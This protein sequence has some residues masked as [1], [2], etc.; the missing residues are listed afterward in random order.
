MSHRVRSSLE[1]WK[2]LQA[3][4]ANPNVSY[5]P[6]FVDAEPTGGLPLPSIARLGGLNVPK[7]LAT[8]ADVW[9]ASGLPSK[10]LRRL[11]NFR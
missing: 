2:R 4:E 6:G 10:Q 9:F 1:E 8:G 5:V 7:K 11:C 3:A